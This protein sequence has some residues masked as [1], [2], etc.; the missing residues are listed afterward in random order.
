MPE[1]LYRNE[2]ERE[3]HQGLIHALSLESGLPERRVEELYESELAKLKASAKVM[4][5]LPVLIRRRIRETLRNEGNPAH[6]S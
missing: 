6:N 5:Y 2:K 3:V 1:K 4:E